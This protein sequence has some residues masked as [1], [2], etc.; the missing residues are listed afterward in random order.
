M[1]RM[2]N[3]LQKHIV[4]NLFDQNGVWEFSS[5]PTTALSTTALPFSEQWGANGQQKHY[6]TK[7]KLIGVRGYMLIGVRGI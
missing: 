2:T 5:S 7:T 6:A 4:N 3:G 1:H